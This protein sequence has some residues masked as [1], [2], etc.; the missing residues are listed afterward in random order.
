MADDERITA[1]LSQA[2]G[3]DEEA[4]ARVAAWAYDDLERLARARVRRANAPRSDARTL[5][6]AELVNETFLRLIDNPVGFEN[7]RHFLAFA[8]R[9]MLNALVDYDR[10]R[11]AAKRGGDR[12]RVTLA[13][14]GGQPTGSTVGITAFREALAALEGHDRRKADVVR[15]RVLWGFEVAE[16]ARLLEVSVPTIGRD[17]QF[18]RLWLEDRLGL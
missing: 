11:A 14:L 7:R 9:L 2:A 4:F 10:R 12:V 18:A 8:S 6:P 1:L 16:I 17:W 15:L 5:E 13:A 3:G